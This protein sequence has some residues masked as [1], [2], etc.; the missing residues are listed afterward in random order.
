[1]EYLLSHF[2]TMVTSED[3]PLNLVVAKPAEACGPIENDVRGKAV[4]VRRGTCAFVK[5]AEEIQAAGG[6]AM[7]VGSVHPY[8][9]RMVCSVGVCRRKILTM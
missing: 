4:L 6:T 7:I 3:R 2:G 1:M 9:V 5:K 8:L